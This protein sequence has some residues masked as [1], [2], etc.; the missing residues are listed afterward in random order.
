[1]PKRDAVAEELNLAEGNL[2]QIRSILFGAQARGFEQRLA[3]LEVLMHTLNT[4]LIRDMN[5]HL[6]AL[7]SQLQQEA[8]ERQIADQSLQGALDQSVDALS[9]KVAAEVKQL[10]LEDKALN[11][12]IEQLAAQLEAST[13][14][15]NFKK[16]DRVVLADLLSGMAQRI[17]ED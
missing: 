7:K 4:Q 3:D 17:R 5:S 8:Q 10:R 15:L 6:E 11:K 9:D 12:Q 14:E 1:M 16:A 2:E 13:Q